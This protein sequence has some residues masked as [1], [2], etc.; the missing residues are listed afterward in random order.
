VAGHAITSKLAWIIVELA[1]LL[2]VLLPFHLSTREHANKHSVQQQKSVSMV[3]AN[4]TSRSTNATILTT[5]D[6]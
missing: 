3:F 4:Q 6:A 1:V 2:Y 5:A